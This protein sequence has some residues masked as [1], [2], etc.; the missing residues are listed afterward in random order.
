MVTV[1]LKLEMVGHVVEVKV[2]VI[3]AVY[4]NNNNNGK[5]GGCSLDR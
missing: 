5:G 2:V 1:V 4:N 3:V